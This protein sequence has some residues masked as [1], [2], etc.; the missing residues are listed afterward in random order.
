MLSASTR[1]ADQADRRDDT[2][3]VSECSQ[4][5]TMDSRSELSRP[6][7]RTSAL[8]IVTGICSRPSTGNAGPMTS[9]ITA[10]DDVFVPA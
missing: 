10:S 8:A 5:V 1:L 6:R 7:L 4:P 3:D 9:P 2:C